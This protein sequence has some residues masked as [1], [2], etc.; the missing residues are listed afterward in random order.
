LFNADLGAPELEQLSL[1]LLHGIAKLE[2]VRQ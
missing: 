1:E 2:G